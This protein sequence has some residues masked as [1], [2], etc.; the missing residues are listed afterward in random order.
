MLWVVK[1]P[2]A[3]YRRAIGQRLALGCHSVLFS[4]GGPN[5]AMALSDP[6]YVWQ[7]DAVFMVAPGGFAKTTRLRRMGNGV[8]RDRLWLAMLSIT[9]AALVT[10]VLSAA[11]TAQSAPAM[12]S[13]KTNTPLEDWTAPFLGFNASAGNSS[14]VEGCGS[15]SV[16][17]P[18]SLNQTSGSFEFGSAL[19]IGPNATCSNNGSSNYTEAGEYVAMVGPNFTARV[20]GPY[21][22]R[23][24][25]S[26]NLSIALQSDPS[27][28]SEDQFQVYLQFVDLTTGYDWV[29]QGGFNY[30]LEYEVD[31]NHSL[32]ASINRVF[33]F[34]IMVILTI[35]DMYQVNLD[36]GAEQTVAGN[37][38][39]PHENARADFVTGTGCRI[40]S[41]VIRS[42]R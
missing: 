13:P 28:Y 19:Y 11:P 33:S 40:D 24:V 3:Y 42:A 21:I 25:T 15:V 41:F 26:L 20:A 14:S 18:A 27:T 34:P 31:N 30:Q 23:V 38:G 37:L 17:Y 29:A 22:L 7:F 2:L 35:G 8:R 32:N 1:R 10:P 16:P 5:Q 36:V 39:H 4:R 12:S 6:L 9:V